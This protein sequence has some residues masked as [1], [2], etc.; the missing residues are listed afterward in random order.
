MRFLRFLATGG[1]ST[2]LDVLFFWV[3]KHFLPLN[4]AFATSYSLCVII[5]YVVDAKL[6]F[7]TKRM[8]LRQFLLYFLANLAVM[9]LGLRTF[10]FVH[11]YHFVVDIMGV[12]VDT[13]VVCKILSI[14][15]TVL[16]GFVI[17]HFVVFR[18]DGKSS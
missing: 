8:H 1:L 11:G 9:Y 10:D 6:T 14:P 7:V 2:L 17:M 13:D 16:S 5:R 18:E 12:H 3:L 15:V 4:V